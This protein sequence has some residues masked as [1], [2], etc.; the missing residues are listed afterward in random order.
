MQTLELEND[1][2]LCCVKAVSFP[3]GIMPAFGELQRLAPASATCTHYG[4]SHGSASGIVYFAGADEA[5]DELKKTGISFTIK[6]GTY[7]AVD[8][9]DFMRDPMQVGKTFQQ[10]TA[11]PELDPEGCCVE[12]YLNDTDVRC[13]VRVIV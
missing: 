10:L 12:V 1:I 7:R 4:I 5:T 13:M 2:H 6:K 8:I 3:Q 9:P 11:L